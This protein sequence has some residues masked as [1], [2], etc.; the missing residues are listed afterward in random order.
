M[1]CT[2]NAKRFVFIS[3]ACQHHNQLHASQLVFLF[4]R[5]YC[6]L[7]QLTASLFFFEEYNVNYKESH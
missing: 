2:N 4:V 5:I 7:C 6:L 1:R 3:P